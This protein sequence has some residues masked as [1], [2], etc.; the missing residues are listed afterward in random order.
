MRNYT[1]SIK[2]FQVRLTQ[3][4]I[5][6]WNETTLLNVCQTRVNSFS[7]SPP[8]K[9]SVVLCSNSGGDPLKYIEFKISIAEDN[10][11]IIVCYDF[12]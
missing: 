5:L 1:K 8:L 3:R 4:L 9:N 12:N 2:L 10:I 11:R 7:F 6:A